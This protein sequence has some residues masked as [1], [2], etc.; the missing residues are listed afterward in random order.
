MH[1]TVNAAAQARPALPPRA[2]ATRLAPRLSRGGR[3]RPRR[4]LR[5]LRCD[6][7]AVS[8]AVLAVAGIGAGAARRPSVLDRVGEAA[9]WAQAEG[10]IS[11]ERGAQIARYVRRALEGAEARIA[12]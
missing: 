2:P 3:R 7:T 8:S 1:T 11:P 10:A 12:A 4:K 9:Y 5:W 6:R